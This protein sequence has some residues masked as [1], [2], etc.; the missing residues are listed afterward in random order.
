MN[1]TKVF[2]VY[3]FCAACFNKDTVTAML[4]MS[5]KIINNFSQVKFIKA[6][7][8]VQF[9][10]LWPSTQDFYIYKYGAY[11]HISDI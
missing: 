10:K 2:W 8:F 6:I 4:N 11:F 3:V 9:E 5:L 7:W 1:R